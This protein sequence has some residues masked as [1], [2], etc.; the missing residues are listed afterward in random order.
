[1]EVLYA[2]EL[3]E[4]HA[5]SLELEAQGDK[6]DVGVCSSNGLVEHVGQGV[7]IEHNTVGVDV[8]SRKHPKTITRSESRDVAR[9][10]LGLTQ[11]KERGT[12][13]GVQSGQ[14]RVA[15]V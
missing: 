12:Q 13:L 2:A 9:H 10:M 11:L 3:L 14:R 5:C 7:F 8:E 15:V 6:L 4:L 1:M